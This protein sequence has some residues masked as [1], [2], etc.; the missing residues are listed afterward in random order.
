[1]AEPTILDTEDG[2]YWDRLPDI[3]V[4]RER[5]HLDHPDIVIQFTEI[6]D[7]ETIKGVLYPKRYS[8]DEV[9]EFI[10]KHESEI[11]AGECEA[12]NENRNKVVYN[13]LF[14]LIERPSVINF[15]RGSIRDRLGQ[16]FQGFIRRPKLP[17]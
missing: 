3:E 11:D 14:P 4:T 1:M 12:C 10:A 13:D 5:A 17:L 6:D 2:W 7:T 16:G 9:K 15:V 8:I